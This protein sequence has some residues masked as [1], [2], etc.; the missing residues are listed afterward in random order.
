MCRPAFRG[1]RFGERAIEG[2]RGWAR[3][4]KKRIRE[5]KHGSCGRQNERIEMEP[6]LQE[7][8]A[9]VQLTHRVSIRCDADLRETTR[10]FRSNCLADR[11]RRIR[12]RESGVL[13]WRRLL[14]SRGYRVLWIHP[15]PHLP[16]SG[17]CWPAPPLAHL[18]ERGCFVE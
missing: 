17:T 3:A 1:I 15:F 10:T 4:E 9:A 16:C 7:R 14:H 12:R 5:R 8:R 18:R 6:R 2:R 13:K 11:T